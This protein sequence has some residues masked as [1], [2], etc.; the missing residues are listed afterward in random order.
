M[1]DAV[2]NLPALNI[3]SRFNRS[4]HHTFLS[5][6]NRNFRLFFIGQLISNTGNWLT[7]IAIT[8]L[9]LNLTHSGL[10]V[11]LL[12]AC[13]YGPILFLSAW[14]G[15]IA[16]DM[17]KRNLLLVTQTLEMLQSFAL[18]L[19]AFTPN[20]SIPLLF[21]V[22]TA[23]GVFLAFDNPLRR[24]F[25]SEMVR[26]EDLPNAVI[27]YSTI[28]NVS[29]MFGPALAGFLVLTLGYGW[30][31]A[32]D[33]LSYIAVIACLVMMR[34]AELYREPKKPRVK[35]AV[36]EGLRY[37]LSIPSLRISFIM[38]ALIGTLS[39]NFSVT[40]PLFVAHG[41]QQ[42]DSVFTL[43]YTIFSIGA[44][45]SSLIVANRGLVQ[46]RHILYGAAALGVTMIFLAF[47]PTV[48][49]AV[50]MVFLVG[51]ASIL[52]MT[53]STTL[54][55]VES[56]REM[57]GRVLALQTVLLIGPTAIGGPILGWISD[58]L[59]AQA[60]LVIGGI[61]CLVAAIWGYYAIRREQTE[62]PDPVKIDP[63]PAN[64]PK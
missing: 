62:Q 12:A 19:I 31:F 47:S 46:M 6:R 15:A 18:A 13:Q 61:V 2:D 23:G 26:P 40:L 17:D 20:P 11:G 58:T 16:D 22:A 5:L 24:S 42:P 63:F 43:L 25:V 7:N 41:L 59:G 30:A 35:G 38:L 27:L 53:S 4:L 48:T 52:Y 44:V 39:Y 55:Q 32:L 57:H 60:P 9:V 50:P 64:S 49:V 1:K 10:A 56:K 33:G 29:R 8:L 14:A 21:I 34:P 37:V 51:V 45:V 54:A 28:V 36:R 3:S